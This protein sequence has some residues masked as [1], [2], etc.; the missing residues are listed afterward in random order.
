M[1]DPACGEGQLLS[2]YRKLNKN[3]DLVG[4]DVDCKVI[5]QNKNNA[6]SNTLYISSS[7]C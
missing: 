7:A 2:E 4:I 3:V 6:A 1:L 5:E